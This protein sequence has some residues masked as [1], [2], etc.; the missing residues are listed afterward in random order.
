MDTQEGAGATFAMFLPARRESVALPSA[1]VAVP[2]PRG[3]AQ[4]ILLAEDEEQVRGM[5]RETLLRHNYRV[6][7]A[8]DGEEAIALFTR[9]S[10]EID[11][12]ISDLDMPRVDGVAVCRRVRSIKPTVAVIIATGSG[13]R[14]EI[15]PRIPIPEELK[16]NVVLRKPFTSEELLRAVAFAVSAR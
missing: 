3:N 6:I 2:P 13:E 1:A 8:Q 7:C 4:F 10:D 14:G 16:I 5:I 9:Q 15:A 11:V 12:V